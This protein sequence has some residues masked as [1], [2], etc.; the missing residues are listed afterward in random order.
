MIDARQTTNEYILYQEKSL[1]PPT[2]WIKYTAAASTRR[3]FF[4]PRYKFQTTLVDTILIL[5]TILQEN[6]LWL[7]KRKK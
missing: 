6:G 7:T 5:L 4:P 3:V 2:D 1:L